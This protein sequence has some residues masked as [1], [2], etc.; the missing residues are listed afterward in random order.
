MHLASFDKPFMA[1]TAYATGEVLDRCLQTGMNDFL[2]KP[3]KPKD[4]KQKL[5]EVLRSPDFVPLSDILKSQWQTLDRQGHLSEEEIVTAIAP[6]EPDQRKSD[7]KPLDLSILDDI[8]EM[9]GESADL[10]I[11]QILNE[12]V[13]DAPPRLEAIAQAIADSDPEQ[14]RQSAHG[15][16]SGSVNI[17]ALQVAEFASQLEKKGRAGELEGVEPIMTQLRQAY[18]CLEDLIRTQYL[19]ASIMLEA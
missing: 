4:L 12:Y 14:L 19:D 11:Q 18:E 17:G 7:L 10:I 15:L 2:T 16:R 1:M 6:P 8:R 13:E 3:V 5:I 9:A